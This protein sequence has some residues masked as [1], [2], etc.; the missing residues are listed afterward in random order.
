MPKR[1]AKGRFIKGSGHKS[2]ASKSRAIVV[3]K[4][5]YRSAVAHKAKAHKRRRHH[6]GGAG[7]KLT[8]L[9]IAGAGLA[10]LAGA[11]SPI[12]AIPTNIAKIPGAKTFG[13]PAIAGLAC[14]AAD[15]FIKRNRWLRAAGLVGVV[16]GAVQVGTKGKDFAWV[17]DSG[18]SYS[19]DV[20]GDDD[21]IGDDE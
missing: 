17:G 16:L 9:A 20:E 4:T 5:R 12:Q 18:D 10:W 1:N 6:G 13:N 3:T 19:G 14:L 15:R 21:M 7:V 2:H 11:S 8:H